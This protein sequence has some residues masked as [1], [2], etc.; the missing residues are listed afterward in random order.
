MEANFSLMLEPRS[1]QISD[2]ADYCQWDHSGNFGQVG[3]GKSLTSYLY[4]MH[5]LNA[6]RKVLVIMP[7]ALISQYRRN[8]LAQVTGH[9]Y[10]TAVL[11]KDMKKRHKEMDGWDETGW[12]DVLYVSYQLFI[13]YSSSFK[14]GGYSCLICDEAHTISNPTTAGF[15]KVFAYVHGRSGAQLHLMTAT[16]TITELQTAYGQI[17]LKDPKAYGSLDQFNRMHV[18]TFTKMI[19]TTDKVTGK[20]KEIKVPTIAGYKQIEELN[21]K[22]MYHAKRRTQK[23]V[24]SLKD[25]TLID[26]QVFLSDNH[27]ELYQRLLLER[28]L[29]LDNDELL[30]AKNASALRQMALQIIT[31]PHKYQPEGERFKLD[32][33]E[34]LQVLLALVDMMD[35]TETKLIIFCHFK[36]TVKMLAGL[37]EQYNP[38]LIY[39]ESNTDKNVDKMLH[40]ESCR[41]GILNFQ[42]GGAGFNLQSVSHQIIVYESTGSPGMLEQGIGRVHRNGQENP[43]VVWLMRYGVSVSA[44]LMTKAFSRAE[45]IKD[46]LGD[47]VAFTDFVINDVDIS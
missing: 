14:K 47:E 30:I 26:H 35:L 27:E 6:G 15:Q 34:P 1:D 25:P 24:L 9:P 36:D 18:D 28:M 17:K 4:T 11:H 10:T 23:E 22:L 19:T 29:E 32:E 7:P 12:P 40:D 46:S 45:N 33:I 20:E 38:A 5:H 16:P 37:F 44:K 39:G 41:L 31:N 42:S 13:K 43:V 21:K 2:A 8:F 3:T